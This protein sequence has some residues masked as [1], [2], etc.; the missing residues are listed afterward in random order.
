MVDRI[1]LTAPSVDM[2][3]EAIY[4]PPLTAAD[5]NEIALICDFKGMVLVDASL[6]EGSRTVRKCDRLRQWAIDRSAQWQVLD[7]RPV[8]AVQAYFGARE[9]NGDGR[10]AGF[11]GF[12]LQAASPFQPYVPDSVNVSY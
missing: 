9:L 3:D 6:R 4:L 8:A 10:L 7:E 12:N 11:V 5:A 1:R 2:A